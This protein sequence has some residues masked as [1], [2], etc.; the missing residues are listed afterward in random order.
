M[1]AES[2]QVR[3]ELR[4]VARDLL[5][6]TS[7]GARIDWRTLAET[8]WLGLEVPAELDGADATFAEVAV[9][10]EEMGRA[11]AC[12][13]FLGAIVLGVGTL[14]RLETSPGRD[15]LLRQAASGSLVP[16]AVLATGDDDMLIPGEVPFC[17]AQSTRGLRLHGRAA[18]VPDAASAARLLLLA[19]D[20]GGTLVIVDVEP[21]APGLGRTAQPV[22]D[23][24]RRLCLVTA[25]AVE[26]S[27]ASVWRFTGDPAV[28]TR[29]LLDRAAVAVA[30]DSLGLSEAMLD[31]T[32]R[33]ARVRKQFGRPI[34]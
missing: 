10:I 20:P 29:Q 11:A 22:L 30:C 9:I 25:D 14:R 18:F 19:V 27:E 12:C 1:S 21:E 24:T 28:A 32:T 2:E 5:A 15:R 23:E 17:L 33:Y 16:A 3:D 4:A 26:V 34:G 31:A 8:G 13:S 6:K 7:P